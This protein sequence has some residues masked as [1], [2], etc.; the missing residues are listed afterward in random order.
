M[1]EFNTLADVTAAASVSGGLNDAVAA[2]PDSNATG[3]SGSTDPTDS[4]GSGTSGGTSGG[5]GTSNQ[6]PTFLNVDSFSIA[7]N[8]T[9]AFTANATDAEGDAV[10]YSVSGGADATQFNINTSS[11][12]VTFNSAPDYETPADA[13]EDGI[14][15][16]TITASDG[17]DNTSLTVRVIVLDVN[18]TIVGVLIDGYLG[19]ATVFQDLNNNGA[20]DLSLIHI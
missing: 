20:Y 19:G 8:T 14:Y 4:S 7:E 12:V 2:L 6:A 11:G 16:V 17:T 18:E 3:S 15:E 13:N 5:E 1:D 9:A 10:T